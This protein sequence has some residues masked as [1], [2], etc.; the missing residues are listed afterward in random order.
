MF[1]NTGF[2]FAVGL[3]Y[4]PIKFKG[5]MDNDKEAVANQSNK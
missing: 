4:V 3:V 1:L 2:F 5:F